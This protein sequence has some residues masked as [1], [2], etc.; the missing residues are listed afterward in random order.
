M[1]GGGGK[2]KRRGGWV[3]KEARER[4]EGHAVGG[5]RLLIFTLVKTIY[6]KKPFRLLVSAKKLLIWQKMLV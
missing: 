4:G 6:S 5:E 1:G 2:G 3:K